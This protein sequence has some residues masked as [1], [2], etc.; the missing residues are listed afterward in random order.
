MP[1]YSIPPKDGRPG[2]LKVVCDYPGCTADVGLFTFDNDVEQGM[3]RARKQGCRIVS[4][5]ECYCRK[6]A[7]PT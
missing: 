4:D 2:H 5:D 7:S 1:I 6:H 3:Q